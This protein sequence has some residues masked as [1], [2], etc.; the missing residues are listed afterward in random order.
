MLPEAPS[1]SVP[2]SEPVKD[3]VEKS[4][5]DTQEVQK[6]SHELEQL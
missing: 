1:A 3:T 5:D 2:K 4:G 6:N